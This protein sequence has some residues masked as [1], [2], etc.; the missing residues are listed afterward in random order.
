[1]NAYFFVNQ[2]KKVEITTPEK[3]AEAAVE[4][5]AVAEK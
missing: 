4:T 3:P 1:M 2:T 5:E